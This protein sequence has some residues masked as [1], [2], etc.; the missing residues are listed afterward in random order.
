MFDLPFHPIFVHF[1]V[2]LSFAAI[3]AYLFSYILPVGRLKND[4]GLSALWMVFFSFIATLFTATFGFLQF[5]SVRHD[6]LVHLPMIDHRNWA[7]G[8]AIVLFICSLLALRSYITNRIHNLSLMIFLLILGFMVGM[9]AFK[10]GRLVYDY[11]VGVK[12]IPELRELRKNEGE[13]HNH[14]N[15]FQMN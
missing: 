1:T 2:A 8:T 12:S 6:M 7:I 9:T 13:N 15:L 14:D 3:G 5:N 11:G 10:G 4:L